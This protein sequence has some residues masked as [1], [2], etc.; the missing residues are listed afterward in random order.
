MS[1][2]VL[3][4]ISTPA[5][6]QND[7]L[8]RDLANAYI[9]FSPRQIQR[10]K[11]VRKRASVNQT[12]ERQ[13]KTSPTRGRTSA[14]GGATNTSALTASKESYGSFPS[15]VPADEH[16]LDQ[17]ASVRPISRLAQLDR[18]YL[19][20]RRRATPKS[21]FARSEAELQT[22][23]DGLGADTGFIE[24]SQSA[25]QALQ[26]QLQETYS[27]TSADTSDVDDGED[28]DFAQPS[29]RSTHGLSLDRLQKSK[30]AEEK[31][32]PAPVEDDAQN[33]MD[34]SMLY[35]AANLPSHATPTLRNGLQITTDEVD[36]SKLSINAFPP[37]PVISV[38]RPEALPSQITKHLAVIKTKN[39]TRF[40][41]LNI[42]RNLQ[43]DE[44]GFWRVDC[45]RWSSNAQRDLWLS[46][47]E[48]VCSG[49]LGWATTLHRENGAQESLGV[50][51][52]YCWGEV[53]EHTWLLLW[54]C[55]KGKASGTGS[56]WVDA[57]GIVVIEMF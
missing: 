3:V 51:R 39:P 40:E 29:D 53:V 42:R 48:Y 57:N 5:T 35:E 23:S 22:S 31:S 20:W 19:S 27:T 21:S 56:K 50:F 6:R 15:D 46:L 25:L 1:D 32:L 30:I 55:S 13:P 18:S 26:S 12:I 8:F 41:P 4:H 43:S 14:N 10:D 7:Q 28:E 45:T 11:P 36:F 37:P 54:L 49:L 52:L 24:D 34:I 47:C 33:D 38:A 44:R 2:E 16:H 9:D 17:D